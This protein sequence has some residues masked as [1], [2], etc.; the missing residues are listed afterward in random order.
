[1]RYN[2]QK[3]KLRNELAAEKQLW[4][5]IWKEE[6][7]KKTEEKD[8]MI[9]V[10]AWV[11]IRDEKREMIAEVRRLEDEL[12]VLEDD[13]ANIEQR[14]SNALREIGGLN[15]NIA[16]LSSRLQK[17]E[18]KIEDQEFEIHDKDEQIAHDERP[19]LLKGRY[20]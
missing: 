15:D 13:Y 19:H 2:D 18:S 3:R 11:S 17:A 20:V 14:A 5:K 16:D 8:K 1:M 6:N 9:E 12:T 10:S 7:L 4:I